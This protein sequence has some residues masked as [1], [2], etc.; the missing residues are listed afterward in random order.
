M[1]W[2]DPHSRVDLVAL[3]IAALRA[4]IAERRKRSESGVSPLLGKTRVGID[5]R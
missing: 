5:R 2:P 1:N 3:R 4:R